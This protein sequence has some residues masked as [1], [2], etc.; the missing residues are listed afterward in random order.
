[1]T[2]NKGAWGPACKKAAVSFTFDNLGEAADLE[3]GTWPQ[4]QAVGQ[5]YSAIETVPA[6]LEHLGDIPVTFF[7]EGWNANIYPNTLRAIANAGR[8]IGVHGWRHEIWTR[9][10]ETK[11]SE[12]MDRTLEAMGKVGIHPG[13][14]RPPGGGGTE[15]L[16]YMMR[17]FGLRYFSAVGSQDAVENQVASIPFLLRRGRRLAR[18]QDAGCIL[19]TRRRASFKIRNELGHRL[20]E[21]APVGCTSPA[22]W[23]PCVVTGGRR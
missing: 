20:A 17:K 7:I 12:V 11:Q 13:G 3:M 5:H 4:G 15:N 2:A 16:P 22:V 8:E 1:M 19:I 23:I 18:R 6:L 21:S 9:L 10:N 14:F